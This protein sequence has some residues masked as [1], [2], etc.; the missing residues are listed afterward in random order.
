MATVGQK[1]GRSRQKF[2]CEQART[3]ATLIRKHS[4]A[5]GMNLSNGTQQEAC[6]TIKNKKYYSKTHRIISHYRTAVSKTIV[7]D[8]AASVWRT[9]NKLGCY[10]SAHTA[11][12]WGRGHPGAGSF[13][14]SGSGRCP[15]LAAE[16]P[17]VT[18]RCNDSPMSRSL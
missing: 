13:A 10:S 2:R 17:S 8:K 16:T 14:V 11:P 18:P 1:Y 3:N 7:N 9:S 15:G 4:D 5:G 12:V 6:R